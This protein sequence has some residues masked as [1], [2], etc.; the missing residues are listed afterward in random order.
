[1]S[2]RP[3]AAAIGVATLV[4]G[5]IVLI[6]LDDGRADRDRVKEDWSTWRAFLI[7]ETGEAER[8]DIRTHAGPSRSRTRPLS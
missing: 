4:V 6:V 5:T 7:D 2:I 3:I 1:M 8:L